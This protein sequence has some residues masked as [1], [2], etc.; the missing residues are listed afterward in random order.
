MRAERCTHQCL[1]KNR[2]FQVYELE[3]V[4][5]CCF[6]Y[7]PFFSQNAIVPHSLFLPPN[8]QF[9]SEVEDRGLTH[10]PCMSLTRV[11]MKPQLASA[12]PLCFALH[13]RITS[14]VD[15]VY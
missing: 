11:E 15:T 5:F 8:S 3:N 10:G 2:Y 7:D 6:L 13:R 14:F 1:F 4:Y 9:K 12:R